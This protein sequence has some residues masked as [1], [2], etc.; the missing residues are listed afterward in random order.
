MAVHTAHRI[1]QQANVCGIVNIGFNDKRITAPAQGLA[2]LFAQN[3]MAALH[4]QMV[5]LPKQ[6]RVQQALIVYQCLILIEFL[7]PEVMPKKLA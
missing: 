2:R 3:R 4:D 7:V 5:D 6:F 1:L